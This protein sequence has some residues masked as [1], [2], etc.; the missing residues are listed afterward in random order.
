M[1]E[2]CISPP[3]CVIRTQTA[4]GSC[5]VSYSVLCKWHVVEMD[6][7]MGFCKL[8]RCS[9]SLVLEV[10]PSHSSLRAGYEA[11]RSSKLTSHI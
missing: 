3:R 7:N 8:Q 10:G 11:N 2:K 5:N 1:E 9:Y 4:S 6:G